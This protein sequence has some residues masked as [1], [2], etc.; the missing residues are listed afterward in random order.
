MK[1]H[2][3]IET[4]PAVAASDE[5]SRKIPEPTMLPTTSAVAIHSPMERLSFGG[6]SPDGESMNIDMAILSREIR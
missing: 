5:G 6:R 3:S 2:A 1:A 4:G